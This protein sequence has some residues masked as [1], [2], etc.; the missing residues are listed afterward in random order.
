[1]SLMNMTSVGSAANERLNAIASGAVKLDVPTL[2]L[3]NALVKELR[4]K[5]DTHRDVE[6]EEND[7]HVDAFLQVEVR[8]ESLLKFARTK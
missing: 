8:L 6:P 5:Y 4:H 1:M 7:Y 2:E 3:V